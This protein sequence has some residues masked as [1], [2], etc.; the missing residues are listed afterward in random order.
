MA[1]N[2]KKAGSGAEIIGALL[3]QDTLQN[4]ILG[5]KKNGKPRAI[6]D[7]IKD[8]TVGKKDGK[9]KKKKADKFALYLSPP[10]NKKKKKKKK[11]K[12]WSY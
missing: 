10:R 9:R 6:Y 7:I 12:Y 4:Y 11:S 5:H 2:E 8:F 3:S 1:D